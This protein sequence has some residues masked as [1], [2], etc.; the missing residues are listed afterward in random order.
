MDLIFITHDQFLEPEPSPDWVL[1]QNS[2]TYSVSA[3]RFTRESECQEMLS[4]LSIPQL[5]E[6]AE[7]RIQVFRVTPPDGRPASILSAGH[8]T[9]TSLSTACKVAR[10][11]LDN[12]E[13][14]LRTS[15]FS[16]ETPIYFWQWGKSAIQ[17]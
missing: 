14:V 1:T 3:F 5:D 2:G 16:H 12:P 7:G 15:G 6:G 10:I 4:G 11:A 17:Q 13:S 8:A 9:L